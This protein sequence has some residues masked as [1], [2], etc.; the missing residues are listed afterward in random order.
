M[1]R[2]ISSGAGQIRNVRPIRRAAVTG[3]VSRT[4]SHE[5]SNRLAQLYIQN[6]DT[7]EA[8]AVWTKLAGKERDTSR[9][10]QAIDSHNPVV[11]GNHTG[12]PER[13]VLR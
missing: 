12:E 8:E 13:T 5:A 1:V 6:G 7:I 10:L 2:R 11:A 3:N 9:T 4:S